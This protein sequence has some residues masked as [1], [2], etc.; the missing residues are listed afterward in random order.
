MG[1]IKI[2]SMVVFLPTLTMLAVG[3]FVWMNMGVLSLINRAI[4]KVCGD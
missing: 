1:T 2:I 4:E 3:A